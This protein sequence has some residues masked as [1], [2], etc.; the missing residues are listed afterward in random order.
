MFNEVAD[1]EGLT[2]HGTTD[3]PQREAVV[4]AA[5]LVRQL[6]IATNRYVERVRRDLEMT[7]SDL[8]AM[9]MIATRSRAG[10][11]ISPSELATQ[12]QLSASAVTSLVDRLEQMGHVRR[13]RRSDD[14]RRQTLTIT[15][16]AAAVSG[17]AFSPLSR[18]VRSAMER[19][20]DEELVVVGRALQEVVAEIERLPCAVVPAENRTGTDTEPI[21]APAD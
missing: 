1:R 17:A 19:L 5:G 20:S 11:P 2:V 14:R 6:S 15:D 10:D 16:N 13:G 7:R 12:L 21:A 18:A 9:E 4:R 8:T 3:E